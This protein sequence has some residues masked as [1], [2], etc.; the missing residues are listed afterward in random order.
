[1][2]PNGRVMMLYQADHVIVFPRRESESSG[3]ELGEMGPSVIDQSSV[4]LEQV[5]VC[6]AIA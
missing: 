6:E 4:T 1:M 2:K 5:S 3:I